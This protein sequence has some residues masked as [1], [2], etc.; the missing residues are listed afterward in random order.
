MSWQRIVNKRV[1]PPPPPD[2][3]QKNLN[4]KI[5]QTQATHKFQKLKSEQV[6]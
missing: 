6:L 4:Y 2:F 3:S 1:P 5:E